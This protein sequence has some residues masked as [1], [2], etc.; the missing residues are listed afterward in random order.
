[1]YI[2]T[3]VITV[4]S[5]HNNLYDP[6]EDGGLNHR[7]TYRGILR[8]KYCGKSLCALVGVY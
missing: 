3:Y 7:N 5:M 2:T 6:P 4:R 1:M 8:I